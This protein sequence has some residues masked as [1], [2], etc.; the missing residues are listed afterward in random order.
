ALS[1]EQTVASN[2]LGVCLL[3]ALL[4]LV[5]CLIY[6]F[7]GTWVISALV[8]G[9]LL[10]PVSSIFNCA[11]GWPR[12]MMAIYTAVMALAG[13]GSV[14]LLVINPTLPDGGMQKPG[15]AA[16]ALAGLFIFGA[17]GS[18]WVANIL[19]MQRPRR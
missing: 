11:S 6:G 12:K 4:S 2:W 7:K 1:R 18:T 10:I 8:F 13:L 5:G 15:E 14:A 16:L 3:L 17:I 19:I 9:L